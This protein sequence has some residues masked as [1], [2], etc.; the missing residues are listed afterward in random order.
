MW[1]GS[2]EQYLELYKVAATTIKHCDASVKVGGYAAADP[3]SDKVRQF[4]AFCRDEKLPL[5][6][7]SWHAY[8]S[9]TS[10]IE[11]CAGII[12]RLLDEHGFSQAESHLNE[13]NLMTPEDWAVWTPGAEN[14]RRSVFERQKGAVGASFVAAVL[15]VL[16]DAPVD[17][18]NYYDGQ[19]SALFCGLFD[20]Y[21]VPQK[22]WYAMKAF[23]E[24]LKYPYRAA[25]DVHA[26]Q[27]GIF[28]LAAYDPSCATAAVL[29]SNYECSDSI[30]NI[31]VEGLQQGNK[32]RGIVRLIDDNNSLDIAAEAQLSSSMQHLEIDLP[33][34]S[35]ALL[36]IDS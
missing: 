31:C 24:L 21:G 11:Q 12:R 15:T 28:A 14:F 29:V 6:F 16:Q 13:W 25:V 35:V 26:E 10:L 17:V 36:T 23:S 33:M 3:G 30:C 18:A 4:M 20:Y 5:D 27:E 7:M 9:A 19:P 34:H 32:Q 2:F 8:T 1:D 22:S